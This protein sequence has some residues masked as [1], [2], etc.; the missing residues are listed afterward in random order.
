MLGI[1]TDYCLTCVHICICSS[2]IIT[3]ELDTMIRLLKM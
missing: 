2:Q 1:E 3:Y